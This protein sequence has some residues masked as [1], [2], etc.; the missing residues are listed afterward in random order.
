MV[1]APGQM[2]LSMVVYGYSPTPQIGPT[3]WLA[4]EFKDSDHHTG[5]FCYNCT[6][7]MKPNFKEEIKKTQQENM[8]KRNSKSLRISKPSFNKIFISEP[9]SLVD[10]LTFGLSLES[11]NFSFTFS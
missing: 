2:I 4:A 6:Y 11:F 7:F 5:Y 3:Q 8:E 9:K 10:S 1:A